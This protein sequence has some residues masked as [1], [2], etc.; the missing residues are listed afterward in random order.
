MLF[1][2]APTVALM[3]SIM[4]LTAFNIG[5]VKPSLEVGCMIVDEA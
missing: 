3:S 4:Q 2:A 1:E 5:D